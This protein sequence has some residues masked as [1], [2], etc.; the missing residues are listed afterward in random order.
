MC[1]C[2]GV[3]SGVYSCVCLFLCLI[4]FVG[5]CVGGVWRECVSMVQCVCVCVCVD[6]CACVA[7]FVLPKYLECSRGHIRIVTRYRCERDK[8][9][10][11]A[12]NNTF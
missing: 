1:L 5:V 11:A 6:E 2:V 4:T 7:L 8:D 12:A 10:G 3:W 9:A